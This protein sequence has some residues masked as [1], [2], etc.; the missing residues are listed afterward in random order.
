MVDDRPEAGVMA[1]GQV[2]GL[3][4]DLPSCAE[5]IDRIMAEADAV[6]DRLTGLAGSAGVGRL[7]A[8]V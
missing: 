7:D 1:T 5:L 6:L 8:G 3:I 2:T 4:D